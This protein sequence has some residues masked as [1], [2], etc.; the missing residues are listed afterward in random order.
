MVDLESLFRALK[1]VPY[2]VTS[3]ATHE[4][5]CIAWAADSTDSW[6]WPDRQGQYYWPEDLARDETLASFQELFEG[7]GYEICVSPDVEQGYDK[8]AIY[9]DP[10]GRPTHAARQLP[11]GNWTSKLGSLED[12]SHQ[13][14]EAIREYGVPTLV[15][16]R[17]R[18]RLP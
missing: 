12:I 15:L 17:P 18:S 9:T 14:L 11:D 16:K 5:N 10:A 13:T 7:R 4:Y 1:H 3:E 6:W 8:I 2:V